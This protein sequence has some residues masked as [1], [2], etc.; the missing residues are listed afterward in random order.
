MVPWGKLDPMGIRADA[1]Y[2]R[3]ERLIPPQNAGGWN[4]ARLHLEAAVVG[5]DDFP[6][7]TQDQQAVNAEDQLLLGATLQRVDSDA[8]TWD[9]SKATSWR[10][11]PSLTTGG[12]D[13][14]FLDVW[15][16]TLSVFRMQ[17]ES[18]VVYAPRIITDVTQSSTTNSGLAKA[19]DSALGTTGTMVY[20]ASD[21]LEVLR[22]NSRHQMNA[23]LAFNNAGMSPTL[24]CC[25]VVVVTRPITSQERADLIELVNT[26]KAAGT[27]LIGIM[28]SKTAVLVTSVNDTERGSVFT[29]NAVLDDPTSVYYNWTVDGGEFVVPDSGAEGFGL[30]AFGTSYFAG[31]WTSVFPSVQ[32]KAGTGDHVTIK[33]SV[34]RDGSTSPVYT[35]TV[36]LTESE[37]ICNAFPL[38]YAYSGTGPVAA[39][40]PY[41]YSYQWTITGGVIVS[42][43]TSQTCVFTVGVANQTLALKCTVY[44]TKD[45]TYSVNVVPFTTATSSVTWDELNTEWPGTL[46]GGAMITE[47]GVLSIVGDGLISEI[48]LIS[49]LSSFYVIGTRSVVGTYS[50]NSH[51][52]DTGKTQS[53]KVS[54]NCTTGHIDWTGEGDGDLAGILVKAY[55]ATAGD[56]GVFGDWQPFNSDA[57]YVGRMFKSRLLLASQTPGFVP[58][59]TA[60]NW[61]VET[62]PKVI[63]Y[64]NLLVGTN[65]LSVVYD[66]PF[67]ALPV[68][69]I[70]VVDSQV[71]D[72]P[73]I[74][75]QSTTGFTIHVINAGSR[76]AR[77]VNVRSQG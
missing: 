10:F 26:R 58:S 72:V 17:G 23:G 25:F 61:T 64:Q 38:G 54:M 1:L 51:I 69:Q 46:E 28:V 29:A 60:F 6:K 50:T 53:S 36:S 74:D 73:V 4:V 5:A 18:D 67:A 16:R 71:G 33:L 49:G 48:P 40:A 35:K 45:L 15:G 75:A 19:I 27:R 12:S 43:A 13:G 55:V 63:E 44:K 8:T 66:S 32:I 76:V 37:I 21:V 14:Y 68:L 62:D 56:D 57:K 65:G 77:N 52:V 31:N 20:D 11:S 9:L 59:V 39:K 47:D 7:P 34:T 3:L 22:F 70:T 41:G 2:K 42:G 30:G 24:Y